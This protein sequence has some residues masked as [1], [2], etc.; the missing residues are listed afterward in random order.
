MSGAYL[1]EFGLRCI[2]SLKRCISRGENVHVK[3]ILELISAHDGQWGW[4]QLDRALSLINHSSIREET[5]MNLLKDLEEQELI[6]SEQAPKSPQPKYLL[7]NKGKQFLL[8]EEH[9]ILNHSESR[10]DC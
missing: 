6:K 1:P 3:E 7:T 8:G 2:V 5:L 9:L 10:N 4:Y